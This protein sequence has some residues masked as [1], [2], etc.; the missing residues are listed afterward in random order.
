MALLRS[1]GGLRGRWG[2]WADFSVV[3]AVPLERLAAGDIPGTAAELTPYFRDVHDH[4]QSI[5]GAI[6][7][8]RD[9]IATAIQNAKDAHT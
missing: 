9:T 1:G 2:G 4:L 6:D 7:S 5:T 8:L 3:L